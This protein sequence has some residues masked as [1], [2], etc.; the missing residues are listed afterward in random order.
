[1]GIESVIWILATIE[2]VLLV[3]V[4]WDYY[5]EYI[6]KVEKKLK[7]ISVTV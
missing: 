6:E 1:M 7:K 4:L 5:D 3:P 2:L